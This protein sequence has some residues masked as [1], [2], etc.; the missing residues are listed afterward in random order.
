MT[1]IQIRRITFLLCNICAFAIVASCGVRGKL[2]TAPPMYG[3]A[4]ADY[5]KEN[6]ADN[7]QSEKQAQE[8]TKP[9]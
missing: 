7:A 9:K 4:K 8:S 5:N 1:K 2:E 3:K 6:G